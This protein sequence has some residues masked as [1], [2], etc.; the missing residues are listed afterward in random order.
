MRI[1]MARSSTLSKCLLASASFIAIP[2]YAQ[3][4]PTDIVAKDA[5]PVD[6]VVTGSARP[7]RRF[8][9]SYAV[10]SLSSSKIQDLAPRTYSDLL[11]NV[12]GIQVESSGGEVQEITR[13]RGLPGDRFGF[14]VQQ[15]G[16]Q[17][18]HDID[19][20]F[21]N[22]G[23]GMNRF[24]LMT[25]RVE[26]VRGGPAPIYGSSAS[27]IANNI[28][29][30]GSAKSKGAV[31]L[32]LGDGGLYRL[33]AYQAGPL[34]SN[35]YYA[36]GGFLRYNSGLR[37]S[38]FP[39]DRGGQIRAN[40]KHDFSNGSIKVSAQYLNDHNVFDLPIPINIPPAAGSTA[41]P[42]VNPGASLNP[43]INFFNSFVGY[44]LNAFHRN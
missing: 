13:V 40:I 6:I 1:S 20:V 38:G 4:A 42:T 9:V 16:I 12:P 31:Q 43:Y 22:S 27:A 15:D 17:L 30:T 29:V 3:S 36:I 39:T 2:A 5:Q 26:I 37:D 35:T 21:F 33:D 23:D 25:D 32:T 14:L 7:Q 11:A 28:T 8:D 24:D 10:N 19:G 34:S 18:Y 44:Y 41:F